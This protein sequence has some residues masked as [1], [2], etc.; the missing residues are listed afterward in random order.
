MSVEYRIDIKSISGTAQAIIVDYR[1]LTYAQTVNQIGVAQFEIGGSH[2][3]I[4]YLGR[5]AQCEIWKRD[6]DN[7]ID[8]IV[9]FAGLIQDDLGNRDAEGVDHYTVTVYD[10]YH[11]LTRRIVAYYAETNNRSAF[12]GIPIE[13]IAKSLVTYNFTASGTV[14]DGRMRLATM[15]GV[16]VEAD[17][18]RGVAVDWSCAW[19]GVLSELQK[20]SDL[21]GFDFAMVK[22]GPRAW[23]FR[24]YPGQL[25]TDRTATVIFSLNRGNMTTP[26]L[27]RTR[28]QAATVAIVGGQGEESDRAVVVRTGAD[29]SADFDVETFY[30][31]SSFSSEDGLNSAGD[32][33]LVEKGPSEKF[34]FDTVQ[35]PGTLYG[36]H[37]FLGDICTAIYAGTSYTV[38][39]SG[40]VITV[41]SDGKTQVK[42]GMESR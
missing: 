26:R 8:W 7:G 31:A 30:N 6:T 41:D 37:Y 4:Q 16:T 25:G 13:T 40:V 10:A 28:S 33:V 3:A 21:G 18:G 9:D 20:L 19:D 36:K 5:D 24:Y 2:D 15:P 17:S 42:I 29:Y 34:A 23:E 27:T 1:W 14:A 22:T 32:A 35:T 39:V 11:L 38:Q 12:T